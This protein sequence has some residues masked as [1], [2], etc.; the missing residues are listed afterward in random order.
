MGTESCSNPVMKLAIAP[1]KT[2]WYLQSFVHTWMSLKTNSPQLLTSSSFVVSYLQSASCTRSTT[3][4]V[5]FE[6]G[7]ISLIK[8]GAGCRKVR[9]RDSAPTHCTTVVSTTNITTTYKTRE[10][11]P[12]FLLQLLPAASDPA[13]E[14]CNL[15][16]LTR[17]SRAAITAAAGRPAA[18][19]SNATLKL[20]SLRFWQAREEIPSPPLSSS[21]YWL[22]ARVLFSLARP[23]QRQLSPSSSSTDAWW[24][25]VSFAWAPATGTNCSTRL[26]HNCRARQYLFSPSLSL[27]LSQT[28]ERCRIMGTRAPVLHNTTNVERGTLAELYQFSS[29]CGLHCFGY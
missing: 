14:L 9:F 16:L 12:I 5:K 29:Q 24:D 8:S 13:P 18:P 10:T 26:V 15:I 2:A 17:T 4:L 6:S 27:S 28:N 20:L 22:W 11:L 1:V 7:K 23:K 19:I 25:L 21:H 3:C